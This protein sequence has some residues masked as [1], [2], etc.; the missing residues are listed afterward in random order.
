[1]ESLCGFAL[2]VGSC[3]LQSARP[4][5]RNL[6]VL[7]QFALL[8]LGLA[9]AAC[10]ETPQVAPTPSPPRPEAPRAFALGMSSLPTELTEEGYAA[11]FALLAGAGE[12][13]LIQRAPPW[14]ELLS[15]AFPSDETVQTTQLE[16]ELA[17]E[18]GLA[19]FLAIDPTDAAEGRRQ[20]VGLPTDLSG[21]GFAD[22]RIRDAFTE[23][24]LYIAVN[25][26]PAYL[27]LGVE[28][29]A[30]E[31]D[32]PEDFAEFLTLYAETYDAVKEFEPDT[33]IFPTFQLEELHG[34]LPTDDPR[35]AQWNL[36]ERF[37][38]RLDLLA[39]SSY[40]ALAFPGPAQIPADYFSAISSHTERRIAIASMGYPSRA[41]EGEAVARSEEEQASFLR[42]A[43]D[44]AEALEMK[45]VIW[46]VGQDP[47]FT[48]EGP[49][50][51][52]QSAGLLQQNGDTKSA[53]IVWT[54][55]AQRPLAEAEAF[56]ERR[57]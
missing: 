41:T 42:L 6:H 47:T 19:I 44:E 20:L 32:K 17:R 35:P 28:M 43:L 1:M 29:N 51:Q 52:L 38:P 33:V 37:E 34:L 30:Y 14:E 24:A 7:M 56:S 46:F 57:R 27:A 16:T 53:W 9:L 18:N 11:A 22:E 8:A 49:L 2:P 4:M 55:E 23:Y 26:Q 10:S 45:L 40:P 36:I 21:A 12:V 48:G 39:V 15:G 25:Y 50:S 3:P 13:V 54:A 31:R 5:K